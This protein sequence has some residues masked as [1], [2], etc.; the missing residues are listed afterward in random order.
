M[1]TTN[2]NPNGGVYLRAQNSEIPEIN[3]E[4]CGGGVREKECG[5]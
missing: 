4:W 1:S 3:R 2:V 5:V